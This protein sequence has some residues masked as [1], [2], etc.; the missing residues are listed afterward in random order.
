MAPQ[1][2]LST[3]QKRHLK[4]W[5]HD[6]ARKSGALVLIIPDYS[7]AFEL[8]NSPQS[9]GLNPRCFALASLFHWQVVFDVRLF[10]SCNWRY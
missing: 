7:S 9:S 5:G 10:L 6:L 8:H 3:L 4:G 1:A 2:Q